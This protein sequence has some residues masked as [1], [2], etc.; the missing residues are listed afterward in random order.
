MAQ[1]NQGMKILFMTIATHLLLIFL[2]LTIPNVYS[3]TPNDSA[4]QLHREADTAVRMRNFSRAAEIYLE[5]A[6]AG[7]KEAQYTLGNLY[8]AGRGVDQDHEKAFQWF[9]KAADQGHAKAQYITGTMFEHG[10]GV[11]ASRDKAKDWYSKAAAEGHGLAEQKLHQIDSNL[12][13][14][15]PESVPFAEQFTRAA[16]SGKNELIRSLLESGQSPNMIDKY[17]RTALH[18]ATINN[19]QSTVKLL[20][21]SGADPNKH[22]KTGDTPLHIAAALGHVKI[23]KQLLNKSAD[24]QAR[25]TNGNTSLILAS[26]KKQQKIVD[27]L[28]KRGV[29]LDAENNKGQ[30]ALSIARLRGYQQIAEN[31][32]ASGATDVVDQPSRQFAD[33]KLI[34]ESVSKKSGLD[35]K[36]H[37]LQ[38]GALS[39]KLLGAA[40]SHLSKRSST[41][42]AISIH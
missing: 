37:S 5:L 17:G 13:A 30:T 12:P 8:R 6:E 15:A 39:I 21:S 10:W 33:L 3:A 19:Q 11:T 36:R 16:A 2:S 14:I 1:H 42:A 34:D 4:E 28:L 7:D 41:G 31:L 20:L 22:D 29:Q 18:E 23:F 32:I 40:S 35:P 27:L 38:A 24:T 9:L 26:G 25:D